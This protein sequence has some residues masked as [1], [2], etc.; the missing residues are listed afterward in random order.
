MI[1]CHQLIVENSVNVQNAKEIFLC[2]L[3]TNNAA[4]ET[5]HGEKLIAEG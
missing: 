4:Q 5:A 2:V 3:P 1:K